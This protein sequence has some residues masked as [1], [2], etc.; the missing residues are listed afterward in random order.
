LLNQTA[1]TSFPQSLHPAAHLRRAGILTSGPLCLDIASANP[2]DLK[3]QLEAELHNL[4]NKEFVQP[5]NLVATGA[6]ICALRSSIHVETAEPAPGTLQ[7]AHYFDT[8]N[9]AFGTFEIAFW[10]E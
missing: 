4:H 6:S 5:S 9:Q 2:V 7:I 3:R 10:R 1:L 8:A